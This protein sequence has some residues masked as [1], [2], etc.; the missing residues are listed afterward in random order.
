MKVLDR[1]MLASIVPV[2]VGGMALALVPQTIARSEAVSDRALVAQRVLQTPIPPPPRV[3]QSDRSQLQAQRR[4]RNSNRTR[5][6]RN[7]RH[8]TRIDRFYCQRQCD[9][10]SYVVYIPRY[11]DRLLQQVQDFEPNARKMH[12]GRKDV[13]QVGAYAEEWL[14]D[15]IRRSLQGRGFSAEIGT[16]LTRRTS[17]FSVIVNNPDLLDIIRRDVYNATYGLDRR[18]QQ[19]VVVVGQYSSVSKAQEL[20]GELQKRGILAE[21][22]GDVSVLDTTD[23]TNDAST[24]ERFGNGYLSRSATQLL[25][26]N[27]GSRSNV[28]GNYYGIMISSTQ[29][30]LSSLEAQIR[31]MV[32][33]LGMERGVYQ[34]ANS[35][36]PFVMVGPFAERE[37]AERWERYLKDFGVSN[38]QVYTVARTQIR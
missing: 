20:V 3:R 25:A 7:I 9:Y 19:R 10:Q 22:V 33:D 13:I 21:I 23:F 8:N 5:N 26:N 35:N 27:N 28:T 11:S 15:D 36:E 16:I 32:P 2:L 30:E 37:T 4:R 34:I 24:I 1:A 31:R 29:A 38:A 17:Q 12:Y 18:T 14:A 6:R